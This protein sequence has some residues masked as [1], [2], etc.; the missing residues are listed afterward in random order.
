MKRR[1]V[2]VICVIL[3]SLLLLVFSG[4]SREPVLLYNPSLSAPVGWYRVT[5]S[6][7]FSVGDHVAAWLPAEAETLAASRGYLPKHTP[8]IK[9]VAA[10]PGDRYCIENGYILFDKRAPLRILSSDGQKRALPAMTDGCRRLSAGEC[11]LISDRVATSFDSRY[12]G[13][14]R[15]DRIIGHAEYLGHVEGWTGWQSPV[16][17][18]ARGQGA[19][20]KIKGG[21]ATWD[22]T[23][24]L[25]IDSYSATDFGSAPGIRAQDGAP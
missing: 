16:G 10:G 21:S 18:R 19:Q 13:P 12:F 25:H 5:P 23:P 4:Q 8:V 14:V 17:G 20:G 6:E 9:M 24:C 7:T 1:Q 15:E 3:L 11:M 22:V 2:S